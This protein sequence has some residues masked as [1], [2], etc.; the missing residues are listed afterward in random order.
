MKALFRRMKECGKTTFLEVVAYTEKECLEGAHTAKECGCD[1]LM[2][3]L[4]YDSVNEY[5]KNNSLRYMPFIGDVS[6]RP[7]VLEGSAEKMI[8]EAR[9][10]LS[11]GVYGFDLLAYRYTGDADRLIDAFVSALTCP[12]CI[13]GS[14]DSYEKLRLVKKSEPEYFTIGGAFFDGIFGKA[15]D[16]QI[17]NVLEYIKK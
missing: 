1:I 8:A 15:F 7:S 17:R 10:Y 2:G 11:K 9:T 6:Q 3:T 13:A 14:I 4:F 16:E 5:C 12:V